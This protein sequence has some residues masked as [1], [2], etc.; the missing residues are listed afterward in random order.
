M[1]KLLFVM[2]PC[3]GM[4]KANKILP[5]ILGL[6]NRYGYDVHVH[7]TEGRGDGENVVAQRAG[8]MDLVVCCGGDGTFNET[9]SGILK[10]GTQTPV[11]YIPA[12]STNDFAV[13]LGLK[14]SPMDAAKAI[15]E[16]TETSYDV[17]CFGGRYFTY[18]ASFGIF[19]KAS[20]ATP[21]SMKNTL[22]H[23]AYLLEGIQE[24][25]QLKKLPV[26]MELD[27]EVLEG[28]YLFGAISNSTSL[29]GVF[30]LDPKQVDMADGLF[31]I[32]LVRMPKDLMEL[33]ECITAIQKQT[34]NCRMATF[35]TAK[36]VTVYAEPTMDWT[37]DGEREP[38]HEQVEVENLHHA[39]RLKK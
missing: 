1:K 6:F 17:G 34:Y 4:R 38:G 26:K 31:E 28:E 24:L 11:G 3:A 33:S 10:S 21:Q 22:G 29:G 25:S 35:R 16:G 20:Y 9:V 18:V 32:L 39:I 36:K 13:S 19:T 30:S 23:A 37:L 15:M 2:N 14:S 7:I 8:E 5:D 27:G 12:G